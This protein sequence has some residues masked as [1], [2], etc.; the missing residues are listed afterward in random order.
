MLN[1]IALQQKR[2][3][4]HLPGIP[5][6]LSKEEEA[7]VE[8]EEVDEAT[9]EARDAMAQ[10]KLAGGENLRPFPIKDRFPRAALRRVPPGKGRII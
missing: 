7:W 8:P 1:L 9:I 10:Q 3:N 4:T 5:G 6:V 2:A